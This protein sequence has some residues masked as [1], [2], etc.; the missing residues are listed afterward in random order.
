LPKVLQGETQIS[1]STREVITQGLE[2]RGPNEEDIQGSSK[3]AKDLMQKEDP[4]LSNPSGDQAKAQFE[5][6]IKKGQDTPPSIPNKSATNTTEQPQ[7]TEIGSPI[8]SLTPLQSIQGNPN[9]KVIFIENLTPISAEEMP[10]S[11][12]FFN[13]KRRDIVKREM[14]QKDGATVKRQRMLYDGQ[15]HDDTDFAREMASSL[16]V[17]AMTNQYSV[18]NLA[19]QLKQRNQLVRQLQ[20][21]MRT[22][23]Q[24]VRDQINP[25]FE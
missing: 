13:K 20:I 1:P 3:K 10:P 7:F 9:A 5:A 12:F 18:E 4:A 25:S 14:H 15:G 6:L 8:M 24:E 21:Q 17:F 2:T 23:K 11:N 19:E 22:I 16:G